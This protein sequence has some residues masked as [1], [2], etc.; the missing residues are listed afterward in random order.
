MGRQ[1]E[2]L[3]SNKEEIVE[4]FNGQT[5]DVG[6]KWFIGKPVSVFY[7]FKQVGIWQTGEADA[8]EA[9]GQRPGDIK[10]ADVNGRDAERKFDE[11]A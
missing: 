5:D 6:N 1:S 4:L 11:T 7:S 9:A 10:I 3:F 2:F 8:A